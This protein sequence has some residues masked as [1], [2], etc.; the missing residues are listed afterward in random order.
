MPQDA[1]H[2]GAV[3][4][5]CAE[6]EEEQEQLQRKPAAAAER[7][8]LDPDV[9]ARIG[10][11]RA[12]GLALPDSTR[13]FFEPR[14]GTDLS[15]VRVHSGGNATTMAD[16]VNARAFTLGSDIVFARDAYAP[17]TTQGRQ[18]LAHELTHVVQQGEADRVSRQPAGGAAVAAPPVPLTF[19]VAST[20]LA[21]KTWADRNDVNNGAADTRTSIVIGGPANST[22]DVTNVRDDTQT[23]GHTHTNEPAGGMGLRFKHGHL[24]NRADGAG[25]QFNDFQIDAAGAER[26]ITYHAPHA[27]G[28]VVLDAQIRGRADAAAQ[29]SV[30]VTTEVT[31]LRDY[32]TTHPNETLIGQVANHETNHWATAAAVTRLQNIITAFRDTWAAAAPGR[33]PDD[34]PTVRINDISLEHGGV[35]DFQ[36]N[37]TN[38]HRL[39]RIGNSIDIS[40]TVL[41]GGV[42]TYLAPGGANAA[43]YDLLNAAIGVGPEDA[44]H[45]HVDV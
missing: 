27:A 14:F 42:A 5:M 44:A 4:R 21:P 38:P 40:R 18:L 1:V 43:L 45:W 32:T 29:A 10:S 24:T 28:E 16:A 9:E 17:E 12:G 35:Y 34:A 22:I 31:G 11:L 36:D 8:E 2:E 26:T 3:Q 39:H 37:W 7:P 25:R 20:D 41:V 23:Y 15:G 13:A 6:C 19:N 30:R 33:D